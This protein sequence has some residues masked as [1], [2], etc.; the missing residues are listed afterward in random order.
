VTFCRGNIWPGKHF[1]AMTYVVGLHV[2]LPNRH[3]GTVL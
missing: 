3:V 2:H 1:V